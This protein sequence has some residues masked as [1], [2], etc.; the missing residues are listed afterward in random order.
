MWGQEESPGL[1]LILVL[2]QLAAYPCFDRKLL[3]IL[4]LGQIAAY[5]CFGSTSRWEVDAQECTVGLAINLTEW[6]HFA[7]FCILR[8]V[9][10]IFEIFFCILSSSHVPVPAFLFCNLG[11]LDYRYIVFSSLFCFKKYLKMG[12]ALTTLSIYNFESLIPKKTGWPSWRFKLMICAYRHK[13]LTLT[14]AMNARRDLTIFFHHLLQFSSPV[15][16][17]SFHRPRSLAVRGSRVYLH[18]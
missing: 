12:L 13:T 9:E 16:C 2:G 5:P 18:R 10:W 7:W 17:T 14:N 11:F 8:P 15:V 1:L 6:G 3:F 4:V